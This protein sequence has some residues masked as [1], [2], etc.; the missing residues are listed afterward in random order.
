MFDV[1]DSFVDSSS[2]DE[3][4]MISFSAFE[5]NRKYTNLDTNTT[6]KEEIRVKK[7]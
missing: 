6:K 2:S 4:M 5:K 3:M 7:M 1:V